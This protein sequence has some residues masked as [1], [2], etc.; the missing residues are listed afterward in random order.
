MKV[1]SGSEIRNVAIVGHNDTGKT[2][3]VS[4]LLFNAGATT[5]MGR[6]ED[7]TTATDF[8][9]DE[10]DRKH[11][12]STAIG[13][14]E[15]KNTKLNLLDTPGFG[16]F[17]ME[18]KGAM[19]VADSAAVVVS[20]V[21]GVEV[22]T[23]KVWKFGEE[24]AL[25]RIIV[26]N[27]MDRERASFSRT[28]EALQK[29][30]GK[31]VVPIQLPIGEEKDFRGVIDL[32]AMKAYIYATDGSGKYE[33]TDIPADLKSDADEWREKLIEKVA[34]GD[35]TLMER[36][37]DQGGLSQEEL[38]DGLKREIAHHEIYPVLIASASHNI[39][40]HS[41][42]DAFVSLLPA[43]D[44]AKTIDG[45][46]A[47][48]EAVTF[49]RRPEAFASALVFKT[50]SDPFS[51]RVS[52]FRVYSGTLQSDHSYWN[53]SRE[54]EERIGKLQVL[55]GKQQI[56]VPE[57]RAG[58]IGAVAKLKDTFTGDSLA[59][60]DHQ[61]VLDHIRY[62]EAAIAF[63][64]EPKARGDEDKLGAAIHR[65]I[66]E[67]P[68]IKFHRDEQTKE[69]LIS[70]QGQ[71]HVEI[72]VGKLKKK[73]NVDVILHPPKVPYRETITKPADA[74]GRHKKQSGGHGQFADCKITMEPLPRGADFEFV[75][76]I[77]GGAIPRQYIPA[78]EKGIQ[79]ARIKGYLAGY[80]VV[81]FRVRLKDGQYH[82]VDSSEMAFK[83]AGSLAFQQA[84]ELA[85]PTLLEPI[86]HVDITAPSEYVGDIMGDLN[87]RRG[88]VE[89]VDAEEDT[90]VVHARVPLAEMLTYG[91]TLRSITQGRGSFHMEYSHYEEVPKQFQ[92]KIIAESKKAKEAQ[93]AAH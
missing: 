22:T 67:D 15:W 3:L 26:V 62:P 59:A 75:D 76:E 11:S 69:F 60:K 74:H 92:E 9:P 89:G 51:G 56:P 31:N 65:I 23:E 27:K 41:I 20:A 57:L 12:I 55:Q 19:R 82:D 30:F 32:V 78:V 21:T 91:S 72:V 42:A 24:F 25:P 54:H 84:M 18:A 36:F 46:N 14:A 68:T 93:A 10:I 50:F 61:I 81:D 53:T 66:E 28:L 29:K 47:K 34:E 16:I 7:G 88:R 45:K 70:G 90:Q 44:E 35:D 43:A 37:F 64:V 8:D 73:Y 77:F 38:I 83:I 17:I 40:G 87:S 52:L 79:D 58:D 85:R 2:T 33:L 39:G 6:V 48:G 4:Q 63:A 80:P 86:M 5:R 49:D 13:V 71:L 1:Y